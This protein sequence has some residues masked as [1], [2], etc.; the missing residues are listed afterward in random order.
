MLTDQAHALVDQFA[1]AL[2]FLGVA[3]ILGGIVLTTVTFLRNG[4][5]QR[6]GD[7]LILVIVPTL[8]VASCSDS[9]CSL[10]QT[11]FPPLPHRLR[12]R[13]LDCWPQ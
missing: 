8:D 1:K 7:P 5:R 2:E 12:L 10:A 9:N 13:A 11:L 6:I 4:S 3:I